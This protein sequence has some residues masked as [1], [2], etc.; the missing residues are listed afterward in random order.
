[1]KKTFLRQV[2]FGHIYGYQTPLLLRIAIRQF[3]QGKGIDTKVSGTMMP[4]NGAT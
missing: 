1:L 2:V 3:R 4:E